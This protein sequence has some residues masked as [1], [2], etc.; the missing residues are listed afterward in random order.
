MI[1][2][3]YSEG[4]PKFSVF[5]FYYTYL[6]LNLAAG[7]VPSSSEV[8]TCQ[9]GDCVGVSPHSKSCIVPTCWT[10]ASIVLMITYT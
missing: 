7:M 8:N 5:C 3:S 1:A 2:F 4:N 9:L 6:F 10:V